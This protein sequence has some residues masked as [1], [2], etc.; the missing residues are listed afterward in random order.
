MFASCLNEQ[1]I[2]LKGISGNI[3]C[4]ATFVARTRHAAE[5]DIDLDKVGDRKIEREAIGRSLSCVRE[6]QKKAM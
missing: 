3:V 5:W 4:K 6:K 2:H 1:S